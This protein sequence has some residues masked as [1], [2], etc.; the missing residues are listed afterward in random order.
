VRTALSEPL[1]FDHY[2]PYDEL[3]GHLRTLA[4]KRPDL[5]TVESIGKSHEGRDIWCATVTNGAT[6]P[7]AEKPAFWCDGNIHA[8]EVS[9]TSALVFLLNRLVSEHDTNAE[10]TRC[11]DTRAFYIVPRV[12]PDGAEQFFAEAANRKFLRSSTRPY[13]YDEEPI[14]GLKRQD[15]DGDGR[16]LSMRIPDP[17]G[18]WKPHPADPRLLTRRDPTETG[19]AY[20]RL[21]PEGLLENWDGDTIRIQQNKEGLDLNRN[22]PAHWRQEHEQYGAGPFPTSEPEVHTIVKFITSHP[23]I[24]GGITFHTYSGVL[25]RPFGTQ[26]DE[27]FPAE[28]LWTYEAIGKKGSEI[29]GYPAVSVYHDFRYHP[30]EVITGVFD[31]WL[32]DHLGLFGWTVEIWSPQRQAGITDGFTADTKPGSF[33]FIDWYREHPAEDDLKML[34]W[35]DEQLGGQGY[36]DWYPFDHP[37]LGRVELGGWDPIIAFRNPPL[38]FLEKEIALFPDWVIW[39]ALI[40]PKLEITKLTADRLA[41]GAYRI[42]LVVDNTGWLPTYVTKKAVER[43]VV[44][45]VVAEIELPEDAEL[46]TGRPREELGQLEGRAYKSVSAFGW[47]SDPTEERAKVEWTVKGRSGQVVKVVARHERA[48]SVRAE[49]TL[50]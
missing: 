11:L 27:T 12:N 40:S 39:H 46:V 49:V 36:V 5:I 19:G 32:Y 14:E 35:S 26:N 23:N 1:T 33:K 41:D 18:P 20:Y 48:G 45:E 4:E 24:T 37:Q 38:K 30:K 21:L 7:A 3:T 10:I 16:F 8:T 9:A 31:D 29:T 22:F 28:D 34:K 47:T 50:D 17:N 25:L 13:P 43:K 42:R 6:G 44:R 15:V 2:F